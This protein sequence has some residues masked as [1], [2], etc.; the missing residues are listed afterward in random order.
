VFAGRQPENPPRFGEIAETMRRHARLLCE[1]QTERWGIRDFRKHATW[2]TKGFPGSTKMREKLIRIE[3]LAELDAILDE[4]DATLEFPPTA[5]RAKR[6][7]KGGSQKVVLPEGF[8]DD[9]QD[10]TPPPAE[11][12]GDGG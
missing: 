4:G 1:W 11:E 9:L 7:K 3:S 6:G 10:A 12:E 2:Y 8:R 5:M